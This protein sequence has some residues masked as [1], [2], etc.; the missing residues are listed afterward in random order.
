[1][2]PPPATPRI[3]HITHVD[4][5]PDIIANRGLISDAAM[6]ARGGPKVGIG[7]SSIKQRRL[8]LP[9]RCHAGLHVG[10]CV[11]FYF[12]PRSLMLFVIHCANNPELAY[13]G[14]QGPIVHLEADL[15]AVVKWAGQHGHQWA[16]SLSNAG[17][18]YAEFRS[19]LSDLGEI[20][21]D[22]VASNNFGNGSYT[23]SGKQVKEGKQAE[24]LLHNAFPWDLVQNIGVASP[25]MVV[26]ARAALN[27]AVHQPNISVQPAWY[28]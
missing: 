7:M 5:L 11:P 19:S 10:D 28:F 4:N 16:F 8:T 17:A 25:A 27:G 15:H 6:I 26:K 13:R 1:M 20:D 23:P 14:G 24:F 18:A 2:S 3:Y 12:C 22:A 9:V 21:W